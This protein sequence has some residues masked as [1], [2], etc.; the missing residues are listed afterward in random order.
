MDFRSISLKLGTIGTGH[1]ISFLINN[2]FD[3]AIYIPVVAKF[4]PIWGCGI[5][6]ILSILINLT[7]MWVYIKTGKDW[8]GL[9]ALKDGK[10][11]LSMSDLPKW[12]KKLVSFGDRAAFIGLSIYDPLFATIY[13]RK[14]EDRQAWLSKRDWYVFG[15]AT[16]LSNVGWTG[17]VYGGLSVFRGILNIVGW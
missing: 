17:I 12:T 3:Y 1:S 10:E 2:T 13:M 15:S 7:L 6:I 8:L 11:K 16:I 4:G 14:S 5:M 9:E